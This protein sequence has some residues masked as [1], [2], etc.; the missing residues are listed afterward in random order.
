MAARKLKPRHQDDIRQKI[1]ASVIVYGLQRFF[2]TGEIQEKPHGANAENGGTMGHWRKPAPEEAPII[3][4]RLRAG[5][6]LLQKILPDL[7]AVEH[8]GS[9]SG[10][11]VAEMSDE[12][13]LAIVRERSEG[14][15]AG[16][17]EPQ[18][19]PAQ[20]SSVH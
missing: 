17:A 15:S 1:R 13:L 11:D 3:A 7:K 6:G 19:G 9:I 4:L 14:G 12:E 18:S 16:V 20:P 2:I 10:R 8:S 5:L